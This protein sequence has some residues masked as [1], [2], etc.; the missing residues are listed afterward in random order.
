MILL[1][2]ET[3]P[4]DKTPKLIKESIEWLEWFGL[5]SPTGVLAA[6]L[7]VLIFLY[8]WKPEVLGRLRLFVVGI[9]V[10][11]KW[12]RKEKVKRTIELDI[13]SDSKQI[14]KE[15]GIELLSF[16]PD[17]KWVGQT[18]RE[19]FIKGNKV[20]IRLDY[21]DDKNRTYALAALGFVRKSLLHVSKRYVP[22]E[23]IESSNLI[24]T[25]KI[26]EK[27]NV[28]ALNY[29]HTEVLIPLLKSDQKIREMYDTLIE[30]ENK[31][32]FYQIFLPELFRMGLLLNPKPISTETLQK[33]VRGL[34]EFLFTIATKEY[35]EIVP[36]RHRSQF[37]SIA[38]IIVA[39]SETLTA[40][41]I[42]PYV[43]RVSNA[44][45]EGYKNIYI[46]AYNYKRKDARKIA[47]RFKN[48]SLVESVH[49][50]EGKVY[51]KN[52]EK[53]KECVCIV[54]KAKNIMVEE[55]RETS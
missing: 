40:L 3:T 2:T 1:K 30:L 28:E 27:H 41:G 25:R 23:V 42:S 12:A 52:F 26:L 4:D 47:E 11:F 35:D 44:L 34:I 51:H 6:I 22:E 20:I 45:K 15:I 48:N 55:N 31:A 38:I 36:L 7:F 37:F 24:V 8:F 5:L 17:I 39:R 46:L 9:F 43:K 49:P 19:E 21:H 10:A 29:L 18:T 14:N 16:E 13:S 50:I 32:M 33:E 54:I 53:H